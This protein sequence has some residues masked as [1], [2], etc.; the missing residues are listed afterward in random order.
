MVW[1]LV[2]A[3]GWLF[4]A[5]C[6]S[7]WSIFVLRLVE[8]VGAR[9]AVPGAVL[10]V[11]ED[12]L[13]YQEGREGAVVGD[14]LRHRWNSYQGRVERLFGLAG[15]G[16]DSRFSGRLSLVVRDGWPVTAITEDQCCVVS[17]G[18]G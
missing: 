1:L 17:V 8:M 13:D 11:M 18:A 16:V 15:V 12:D 7:V 2:F 4:A 5:F 3:L 10:G 6:L 14:R 9:R